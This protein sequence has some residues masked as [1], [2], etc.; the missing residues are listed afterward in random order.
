[1][2]NT[3]IL[4]AAKRLAIET[5]VLGTAIFV[6][7]WFTSGPGIGIVIL[8]YFL[9]MI[10]INL[11]MLIRWAYFSYK[12]NLKGHVI[13]K[14]VGILLLNV[15]V[16]FLY[17]WFALILINT[18]RINFI[19]STGS[20]ITNLKIQGCEEKFIENLSPKNNQRVWVH[21]EHD[22]GIY[23]SYDINGKLKEEEVT[24]YVTNEAGFKMTFEIGTNQKP[25]GVEY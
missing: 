16:A 17:C 1:M 20:E 19:N 18:V 14:A 7:F 24:G 13:W 15:P 12:H 8:L 23:I 11:L 22:C 5:F 2:N 6:F 10:I 21:I 9:I 25:Y 3:K 4:S